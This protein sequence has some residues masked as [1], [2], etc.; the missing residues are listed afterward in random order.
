MYHAV[1][2]FVAHRMTDQ[3]I[4][5]VSYEDDVDDADNVMGYSSLDPTTRVRAKELLFVQAHN[6]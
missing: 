1:S 6:K 5:S 3:I 2:P 4:I